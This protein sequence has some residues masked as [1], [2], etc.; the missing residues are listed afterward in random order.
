MDKHQEAEQPHA[1]GNGGQPQAEQDADE[2]G[3]CE[4]QPQEKHKCESN[5]F[6]PIPHGQS[7]V[8]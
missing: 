7:F 3:R 6:N 8:K 5:S 2:V 4:K 1:K